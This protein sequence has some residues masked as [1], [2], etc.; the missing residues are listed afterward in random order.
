MIKKSI[1]TKIKEH[2]LLNPTQLLR[3]RQI[4]RLLKLPLPSVIRYTYELEQEKILKKVNISD[5]NFYRVHRSSGKFILEKKLF[6]IKSLYESGLIDYLIMECN[7]PTIV[8]FFFFFKGEDVE[9]SDIDLYIEHTKNV[10]NLDKF[11]KILERKIQVFNYKNIEEI[12]NKELANNIINGMTLN[13]FVEV[14]R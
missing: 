1:K 11:E 4:E 12:K 9:K 3:V 2:F 14:F 6:N 8:L 7:N 10:T 5:V 13:G